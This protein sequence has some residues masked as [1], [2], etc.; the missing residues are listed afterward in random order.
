MWEK[1]TEMNNDKDFNAVIKKT[2]ET[3]SVDK[4]TDKVLYLDTVESIADCYGAPYYMC[5]FPDKTVLMIPKD[6]IPIERM[7]ELYF[8]RKPNETSKEEALAPGGDNKV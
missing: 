2:L 1:K 6:L 5:R 8:T 3:L 4:S 7:E